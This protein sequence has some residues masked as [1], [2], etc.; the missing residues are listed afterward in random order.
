MGNASTE[1]MKKLIEEKKKKGMQKDSTGRASN[2]SNSGPNKGFKSN[3]RAGS[4]NK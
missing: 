3:K 4:L 1:Q 2:Q